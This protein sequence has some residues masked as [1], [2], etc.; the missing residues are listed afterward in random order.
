VTSSLSP[1]SA[2]LVRA[3][4]AVAGLLAGLVLVMAVIAGR[5]TFGTW[6]IEVHGGVGNAIFVVVLVNL[7][8]A[9]AARTTTAEIAVAGVIVVLTFAQIGLG[10]VGRT[11]LEAAAWHVP[12]G[13]LLMALSTWQYAMLRAPRPI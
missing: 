9:L 3:R 4:R 8:L 2:A 7:V 13:V 1:Q 11:E 12:N 6:D 5:S 10:Y